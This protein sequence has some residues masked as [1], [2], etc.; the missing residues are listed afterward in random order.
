ML[1]TVREYAL[2]RARRRTEVRRRHARAFVELLRD[3]ERGLHGPDARAWLARLDAERENVHAA[4]EFAIAE[5]DGETAVALVANV[6]R[7]WL[8]RGSLTEGRALA[9]AALALDGEPSPA[10]VH[11]LNGA[12]ALAAEQGDFAAARA[13]LRGGAATR[14]GRSA[15]AP[16]PRAPTATSAT[17]RSTPATTPR[18][19]AATRPRRRTCASPAT[20]GASA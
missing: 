13:A 9:A 19:C 12:G 14:R 10:R 6:W 16:A 18:P 2:E 3:A 4:L 7:H 20:T 1:E 8:E 17:S 5:R 11:A 15:T